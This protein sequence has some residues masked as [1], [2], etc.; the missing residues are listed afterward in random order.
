MKKH[1]TSVP[2]LVAL[3]RGNFLTGAFI[4]IPI[5]VV[6]WL[7]LKVFHALWTFQ[8]I[9][10]EAWKPENHFDTFTANLLNFAIVIGLGILL[11]FL[12]S[13]FGW[14]SKQY[15][16]LRILDIIAHFIERIPVIRSVYS[17]LSQLLKTIGSGDK[18]QFSRVVYLEYPRKGAY[19]LAFV[20]GPAKAVDTTHGQKPWLN[21]YVPTTPN[22]TSGFHL[23]VNE[24]EVKDSGMSVEEAFK[25]ILSLGIAR[26][27]DDK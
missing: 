25:V 21:V 19:A 14:I 4:L 15:I 1:F 26:K 12:I 10:P 5:G 18:K 13:I 9:L 23:I 17:S 8:A 3:F 6:A 2:G 24:D 16:G 27:D 11:L 22:P 7:L 20:T